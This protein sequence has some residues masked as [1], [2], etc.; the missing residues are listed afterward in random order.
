M[1]KYAC[2]TLSTNKGR[3]KVDVDLYCAYHS[4]VGPVEKDLLL[5]SVRF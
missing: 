1:K 5:F 2:C 4:K 3:L